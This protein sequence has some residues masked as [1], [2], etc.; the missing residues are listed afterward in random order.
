MFVRDN[1]VDGREEEDAWKYIV[2][3]TNRE[4]G[5][6]TV[7]EMCMIVYKYVEGWENGW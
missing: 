5:S 4:K 1:K 7:C 2:R 6:Y 3:Q